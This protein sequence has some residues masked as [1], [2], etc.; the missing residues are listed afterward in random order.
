[1]F[2]QQRQDAA[3]SRMKP[4]SSIRSAI[5]HEISMRDKSVACCGQQAPRPWQQNI[6]RLADRWL[7]LMLLPTITIEFSFRYKAVLFPST[8]AA[9]FAG[10][11]EESAPG[12][13]RAATRWA[14]G[15]L[16]GQPLGLA[17]VKPA[18]L[19][20]AGLRASQQVTSL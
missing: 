3:V 1:M 7:Q 6:T 11:G 13:W 18:R 10:G 17:K 16:V 5:Q 8:C 14:L 20:S 2:E 4:M 15:Y 12:S 19:A 9:E